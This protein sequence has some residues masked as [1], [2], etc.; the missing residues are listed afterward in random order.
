[1]LLHISYVTNYNMNPIWSFQCN[2]NTLRHVFLA[3]K[4]GDKLHNISDGLV[5][6][7]LGIVHSGIESSARAKRVAYEF[8]A[9][10]SK[11]KMAAD[12]L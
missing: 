2:N 10:W 5:H 12:G 7:V 3:K 9:M 1:M 4:N 11:R 8:L 6:F